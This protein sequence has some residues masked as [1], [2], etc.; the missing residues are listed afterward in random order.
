MRGNPYRRRGDGRGTGGLRNREIRCRRGAAC[1]T[2]PEFG[3]GGW[4]RP[5]ART[6]GRGVLQA[7]PEEK[8]A[9]P[10]VHV[11][12][13]ETMGMCVSYVGE[14]HR[15]TT[16]T[17]RHG[18]NQIGKEFSR[19][20]S[21]VRRECTVPHRFSRESPPTRTDVRWSHTRCLAETSSSPLL[22]VSVVNPSVSIHRRWRRTAQTTAAVPRD[23]DRAAGPG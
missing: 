13:V 3:Q 6:G 17:R 1:R 19:R 7:D 23:R 22:Q 14:G 20:R 4:A 9:K 11:S 5:R 15:F 21:L 2:T 10:A 12:P 16:E 8:A 18:E